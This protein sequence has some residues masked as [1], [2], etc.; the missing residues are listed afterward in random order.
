MGEF[1]SPHILSTF[2]SL[3]AHKTSEQEGTWC[4]ALDLRFATSA[5]EVTAGTPSWTDTTQTR[6]HCGS[7]SNV[8]SAQRSDSRTLYALLLSLQRRLIVLGE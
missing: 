8:K 1:K 3:F 2:F 5:Q 4:Q 6:L 7:V